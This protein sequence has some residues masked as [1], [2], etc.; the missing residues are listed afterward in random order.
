M[1]ET[2]TLDEAR[3]RAHEAAMQTDLHYRRA[4]EKWQADTERRRV[5]MAARRVER[6]RRP[7]EA[8]GFVWCRLPMLRMV[9]CGPKWRQFFYEPGSREVRDVFHEDV[10]ERVLEEVRPGVYA[11]WSDPF[12]RLAIER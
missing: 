4:H 3:L 8:S 1:T 10:R 6:R 2:I 12:E 5:E 7:H 11:Q 9:I